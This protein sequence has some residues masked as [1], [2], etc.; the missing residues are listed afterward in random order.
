MVKQIRL[1]PLSRVS[2]VD[3][4]SN[5]LSAILS[6]ELQVSRECNGRGLCATCH[7]YVKEGMESLTPI[8]PR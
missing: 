2:E 8:T 5:L 7:V 3:T 6:E 1:E 4:Y